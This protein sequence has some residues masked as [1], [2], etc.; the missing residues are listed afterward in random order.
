MTANMANLAPAGETAGEEHRVQVGIRLQPGDRAE[1]PQFS[2]FS[3]VQ[4]GQ[5]MVFI[6]FGFL[7]PNALPSVIRLA[8][9]GGKVPEAINGRL[10]ARIVLRPDA[11]AQLVQQLEQHLRSIRSP[12][13]RPGTAE[14]ASG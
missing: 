12:A 7:E 14:A 10:A 11:A 8:Q 9:S 1:S 6:D 5:G 13:Q 3:V 4:G 2:N